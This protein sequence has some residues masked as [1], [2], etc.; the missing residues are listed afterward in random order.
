MVRG[1]IRCVSAG[2][3]ASRL[4][5]IWSTRQRP[6]WWCFKVRGDWPRKKR[7]ERK[8]ERPAMICRIG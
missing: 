7:W 5:A 2:G 4:T 6:R 3:V 1:E 8:G